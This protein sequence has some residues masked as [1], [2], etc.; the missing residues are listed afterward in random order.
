MEGPGDL[1]ESLQCESWDMEGLGSLGKGALGRGLKAY[2]C[3]G[4]MLLCS[5]RARRLQTKAEL[6]SGTRKMEAGGLLWV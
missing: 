4:H 3:L 5:E 6:R 2:V 1:C